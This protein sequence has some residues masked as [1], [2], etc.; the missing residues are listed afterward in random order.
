MQKNSGVLDMFA[1]LLSLALAAF[2]LFFHPALSAD[3]HWNVIAI[4]FLAVSVV[5]LLI[6]AL[7]QSFSWSPLQ[8][9]E[10]DLT[11]RVVDMFRKD[12]SLKISNTLIYLFPIFTLACAYFLTASEMFNKTHVV[13]VWGVYL[14]L[15]IDLLHHIY[16]KTISYFSPFSVVKLFTHAA[17][18][19]IQNE[20]EIDLCDCIDALSEVSVKAIESSSTSLGNEAVNEIQQIARH[21]LEASKSI[22]HHAQDKQTQEYGIADKVSFT[23]FY[24]FQRLEMINE[25]AVE[26]HLEP[27]SSTVITSLGKIALYSAKYDISLASYPLLFLGKCAKRAQEKGLPEVGVKAS[28]TLQ[29]VG[30][31]IPQEI[32]IKYLELQDTYLMLIT[33]LHEITKEAFKQDKSLNISM[34]TQ[35][36]RDMKAFF[37]SEKLAQH[38]D[39]PVIVDRINQVIGEFDA[40]EVILKT[41]PPIPQIAEEPAPTPEKG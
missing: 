5:I 23:L 34:L 8:K 3:V 30:K 16:N 10:K 1:T 25:K 40:L 19:N 32:D 27:I 12:I 18:T 35:P 36:F 39:T 33:Q 24:L 22:S 14:G 17:K 21:F 41:L 29:E 7:F 9:A 31:S 15:A 37:A 2:I 20:R 6:Q 26:K 38:Q 28:L 13:I 4:T 11:P